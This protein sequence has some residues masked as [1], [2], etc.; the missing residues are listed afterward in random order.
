MRGRKKIYL[1]DGGDPEMIAAIRAHANFIEFAPLCLLLIYMVERLLRLLDHGDPVGPAAAR[2][3]AA[4]RRH[5]GRHSA[6]AASSAPP[7]R[8]LVL[9]VASVMLVI[10]GFNLR[11]Y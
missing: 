10:A 6:T 5:A 3:R 8:Q 1:G 2:A 9:V 4:C 7:A 11:Q